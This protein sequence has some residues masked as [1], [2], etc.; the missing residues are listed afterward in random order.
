MARTAGFCLLASLLLLP[1]HPGW[2]QDAKAKD[3][4]PFFTLSGNFALVSDYRFRGVSLSDEDIAPQGGITIN[5]APGFFIGTWASSIEPLN[6]AEA[7]VDLIAGYGRTIG[8]L[9]V[10]AGVT[11]YLYPGGRDTNYVEPY[12]SLAGNLGP[13]S[14]TLTIAYAPDQRNIGGRDNI[15]VVDNASLPLGAWPL[16]LTGSL[17]FEDGAFGDSRLSWSLGLSGTWH[18]LNL[19]ASYVDTDQ[20][21]QATDATVVFAIGMSF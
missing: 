10:T 8:A 11:A 7:E 1:A 16:A 21:G 18:G 13:V 17:G 20:R 15:Y 4:T 2:A 9:S 19:S 3:E 5:T 6:G 12:L 14:N